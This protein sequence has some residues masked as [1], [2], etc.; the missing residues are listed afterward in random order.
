MTDE[1]PEH[2]GFSQELLNLTQK[3]VETWGPMTQA[4]KAIEE[5]S[6]MIQELC[7]MLQY[8]NDLENM[9]GELADCFI[10]LIQ[11]AHVLDFEEFNEAMIAKMQKLHVAIADHNTAKKVQS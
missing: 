11:I 4:A 7:L 8:E 5:L 6:E 2:I 9:K 1:L 3:A 10:T